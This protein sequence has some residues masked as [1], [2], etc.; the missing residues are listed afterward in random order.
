MAWRGTDVTYLGSFMCKTRDPNQKAIKI[1]SPPPLQHYPP[2]DDDHEDDPQLS[3]TKKN[4]G[5]RLLK[6]TSTTSRREVSRTQMHA[7]RG[8]SA[9]KARRRPS[10]RPDL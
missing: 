5:R 7:A 2:D 10:W 4:H 8:A 6:R 9:K 1:C 3:N